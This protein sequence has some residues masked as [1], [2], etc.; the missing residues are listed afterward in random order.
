[1]A[2][3]PEVPRASLQGLFGRHG[4][5]DVC[6]RRAQRE[7]ASCCTCVPW[8]GWTDGRDQ[9]RCLR[10]RT[11]PGRRCA[12]TSPSR[13]SS[14]DSQ[15]QRETWQSSSSCGAVPHNSCSTAGS[16]RVIDHAHADVTMQEARPV[17][18]AGVACGMDLKQTLLPLLPSQARAAA[19]RKMSEG[20]R[21]QFAWPHP[22]IPRLEEGDS[23]LDVADKS[24][25]SEQACLASPLSAVT[26]RS[27][28]APFDRS[29]SLHRGAG[30]TAGHVLLGG[31]ACHTRAS[32]A[33][34]GQLS[35]PCV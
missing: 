10:L 3:P 8:S 28:T 9:R 13:A 21:A 6:D 11:A 29:L 7:G 30:A 34:R 5:P 31:H 1:V 33:E 32:P 18:L 25:I 16:L 27:G 14:T 20:G 35:R 12:G 2:R 23:A 15:V 22:G 19:W 26:S 24:L 4:A 17:R